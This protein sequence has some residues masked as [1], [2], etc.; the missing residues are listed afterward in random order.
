MPSY[1][2]PAC[3]SAISLEDVN[4]AT[5]LALCRNCGTTTPFSVVADTS[6]LSLVTQDDVPKG[7]TVTPALTGGT[8][9][10]YRRISKIVFF[11]IPFMMIWSGFSLSGIYGRQIIRGQ[12][13]VSQSLFGLPFLLGTIM[14]LAVV[15]FLLFGRWRVRMN[16]GQGEVFAGVGPAGWT[17]SFRYD[18]QSRVSL[19]LTNIQRNRVPQK[20]I[21]VRTGNEEI[22]FGTGIQEDAKRFI[23]AAIL[24]NLAE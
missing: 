19:E 6:E 8:E 21:T 3:R 23:A 16:A 13:D 9:I 11:L 2:C 15:L 14:L 5:D 12:F 4:I 17:R 1:F 20:A 18:P 22:R 10:T 7:V 24:K